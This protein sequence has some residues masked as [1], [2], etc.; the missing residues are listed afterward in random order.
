MTRHNLPDPGVP[1]EPEEI[2][3]VP[4]ATAPD[5]LMAEMWQEVL[6]E[7]LIP[8]MLAPQDVVSFL[9]VTSAP[10]RLMVPMEMKARAEEVLAGLGVPEGTDETEGIEGS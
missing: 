4:V 2:Q 1:G 5:Q 9:G 6:Y 7:D 10:V 8:T 3:W